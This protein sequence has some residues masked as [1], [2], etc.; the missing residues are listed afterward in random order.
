[1]R[2]VTEKLTPVVFHAFEFLDF[3][4]ERAPRAI[5]LPDQAVQLVALRHVRQLQV[6]ERATANLTEQFAGQRQPGHD[7]VD[8]RDEH[9]E[10]EDQ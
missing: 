8:R 2:D 1:M 4:F 7:Q 3:L 5:D 6:L 10:A 9:A